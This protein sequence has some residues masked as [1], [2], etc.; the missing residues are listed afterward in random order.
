MLYPIESFDDTRVF[1]QRLQA[2][3][4]LSPHGDYVDMPS[5]EVL[6][7]SQLYM[8][9]ELMYGYGLWYR[10]DSHTVELF[11]VW[12][13]GGGKL[14][15]IMEHATARGANYLSCL[16]DGL[17]DMYAEHGFTVSFSAP[18]NPALAPDGI[19]GEPTYYEM[20]A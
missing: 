13:M 3:R 2:V 6:A 17:R 19:E 8:D 20:T 18:F 4:V 5:G 14:P 16:G 9:T 1:L 15:E 11:G 10:P 7:M 12:S